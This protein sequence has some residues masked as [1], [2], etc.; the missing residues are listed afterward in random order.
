MSEDRGSG[1]IPIELVDRVTIGHDD[2]EVVVE[3]QLV[4]SEPVHIHLHLEFRPDEH[5][6][7]RR[8]PQ[9]VKALVVN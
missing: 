6:L 4:D 5:V 1:D 7:V 3:A 2:V 8:K 9:L